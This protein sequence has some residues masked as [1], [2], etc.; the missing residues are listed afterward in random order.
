MKSNTRY[1]K[2]CMIARHPEASRCS[3]MDPRCNE[4]LKIFQVPEAIRY[5]KM[6]SRYSENSNWVGSWA[7]L[8]VASDPLLKQEFAYKYP[9]LCKNSI[10]ASSNPNPL[11]F[12]LK[13]FLLKAKIIHTQ[14]YNLLN[15]QFTLQIN[16]NLCQFGGFSSGLASFTMG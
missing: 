14:P 16:I 7:L 12:S 9:I 13:Y 6:D 10:L 11:L 4:N 15:I 3:E 2:K 1:N 5:N 8:V